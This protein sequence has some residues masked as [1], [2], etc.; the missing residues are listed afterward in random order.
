MNYQCQ[1]VNLAEYRK[2]RF[3]NRNQMI[4]SFAGKNRHFKLYL[5]QMRMWLEEGF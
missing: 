5:S 2:K 4:A 1:I 3:R